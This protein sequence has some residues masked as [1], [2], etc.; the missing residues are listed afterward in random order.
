MQVYLILSA[1]IACRVN[2]NYERS[3]SQ[4]VDRARPQVPWDSRYDIYEGAS[5]KILPRYYDPYES[6]RGG[7]VD[8]FGS[9]SLPIPSFKKE[10]RRE[11]EGKSL[12]KPV[13]P[14][15]ANVDLIKRKEFPPPTAHCRKVKVKSIGEGVTT[16]YKCKDPKTKSAYEHCLYD[17]PQ[18]GASASKNVEHFLSAPV[19]FR[20]RR[21]GCRCTLLSIFN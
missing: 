5:S 20:Y 13:I 12:K 8:H 3:L 17:G 14:H 10:P 4:L 9:Y 18:R 19:S 7:L 11:N 1:L 2:A 15:Y 16:C 21:Y 6:S